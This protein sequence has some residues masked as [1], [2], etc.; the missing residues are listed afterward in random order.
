INLSTTT[1]IERIARAREMGVRR[2]Q[3]SL[4]SW[5][6]LSERELFEFFRQTCGRFPDCQFLHYNLMRTKRLVTPPEYARLAADH[7]NLAAPKNGTDDMGR[8]E[9]LILLAPQLQHFLT[10]PGYAYGIQ[11]GECG[12]LGSAVVLNWRSGQAFFEAGQRRDMETLTA[13]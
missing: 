13:M 9:D 5:G 10:E 11:I 1:I 8:I 2:F 6:A 4:P 3:I 7:P 12:L